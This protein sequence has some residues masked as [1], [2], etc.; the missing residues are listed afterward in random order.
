MKISIASDHG[1]YELKAWLVDYLTKQGHE[2]FD[3]GCPSIESVDYPDFGRF[4][5]EDMQNGV[6]DYGVLVCYT[7]IG[8]SIYANKFKGI[9]AALVT[10]LE[11]AY[12]TRQHNNS[13]VICLS[14]KFT[15]K[16]DA[17]KYVDAFVSEGFEAGR[18]LRRIN[19][20][21]EKEKERW[22]EN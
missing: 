10:N 2:V 14:G 16:E 9:R 19:K 20:I 1:G 13:N 22:A 4:V 17:G 12:L 18:H 11:S 8:M 7:G 6:C 15:K 5:C 21:T 3:R